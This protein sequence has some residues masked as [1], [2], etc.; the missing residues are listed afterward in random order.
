MTMLRLVR[1]VD[2]RQR[3]RDSRPGSSPD[4]ALTGF[5]CLLFAL[6]TSLPVAAEPL[7]PERQQELTHLLHQ[8]CGSCHGLHLTGGLGPA[9][10]PQALA[11]KP[12]ALLVATVRE[13]R[14]GTPMPPWKH[15]LDDAEIDWLVD[16]LL[17]A[18]QT[19]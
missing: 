5:S 17:K 14:S 4:N 3:T 12:R 8:D 10:T 13:G 9:L 18:D 15:L 6:L 2:R 16:Y 7:A 11:G 19:P 1:T